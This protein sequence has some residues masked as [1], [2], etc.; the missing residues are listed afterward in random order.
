MAACASFFAACS[1]QGEGERCSK[2]AENQGNADC[3]DG[4]VCTFI[5]DTEGERCCPP[6]PNQATSSACRRPS[7]IGADVAPPPLPD[8]G[9]Q[10]ETGPEEPPDTGA[11][12]AVATPPD[13]NKAT[14]RTVMVP[15]GTRP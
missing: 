8:S 10:E 1:N 6:D 3:Q 14:P 4:L 11:P 12:D 15:A 7:S 5:S 9:N 2:L 13:A